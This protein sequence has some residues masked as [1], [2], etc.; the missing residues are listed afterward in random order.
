[1]AFQGGAAL[2]RQPLVCMPWRILSCV[3]V[4]KHTESIPASRRFDLAVFP[5][6]WARLRCTTALPGALEQ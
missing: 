2:P 6:T 5:S 3:V 4:P 1:M